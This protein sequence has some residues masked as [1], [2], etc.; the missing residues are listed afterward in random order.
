MK[1]QMCTEHPDR[2]ER[3]ADHVLPLPA[4]RQSFQQSQIVFLSYFTAV[5][6]SK[7]SGRNCE[8]LCAG[9]FV[10]TSVNFGTNPFDENVL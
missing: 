10:M 4:R 8:T 1:Y 2:E 7:H 3:T 6:L 5:Y 9:H